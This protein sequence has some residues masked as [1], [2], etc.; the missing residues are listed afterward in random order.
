MNATVSDDYYRVLGVPKTADGN[1]IR[2]AYHKLAVR[3]HPDKNPG[4]KEAE[5]KFKA[6]AE[7]YAVLSDDA[8]RAAYDR[9]G[10]D[11]ARAA[12][13]AHNDGGGGFPAAGGFT[14]RTS[15]AG[16]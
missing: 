1:A 15:T 8:K 2:K 7:A 12:E 3:H 11:G 9:Y 14:F 10:K 16:G 5:E 4:D 13:Q 6:I